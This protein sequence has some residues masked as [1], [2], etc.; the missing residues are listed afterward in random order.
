MSGSLSCPIQILFQ[1]GPELWD[2]AASFFKVEAQTMTS[3][4]CASSSAA[5][6]G[7]DAEM[8]PMGLT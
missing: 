4:I 5:D 6:A 3:V 2:A 7:C 1:T 8:Q